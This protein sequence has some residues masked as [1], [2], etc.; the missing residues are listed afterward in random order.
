MSKTQYCES[1]GKECSIQESQVGRKVRCSCGHVFVANSSGGANIIVDT[2]ADVAGLERVKGFSWKNLFAEVFRSHTEEELE[3]HWSAGSVGNI[4]TID[5]VDSSWPQPWVFVRV[6]FL[7]LLAYGLLYFGWAYWTNINLIPGLIA[8]GSFAVPF[9]LVIF[10]FEMNVRKNVSFHLAVKAFFV[11]GTLSLIT[12]LFMSDVTTALGLDWLKASA[13]GIA[14]EPGKILAVIIF[15]RS[16]R[17]GYILNGLLFGAAVGAGFAAFESAGYAMKTLLISVIEQA[18]ASEEVGQVSIKS[19]NFAPMFN[20]ILTRAWLVGLAGHV[21]WT[22]M[23]AGALWRVKGS[24]PFHW[25]MLLDFRFLRIFVIAVACHMI[26]NSTWN[27]TIV[28]PH[29]KRILLGI[30]C[31]GVIFAMIQSGLNQIRREQENYRAVPAS[32]TATAFRPATRREDS[33]EAG[34]GPVIQEQAAYVKTLTTPIVIL[35]Q[36]ISALEKKRDKDHLNIQDK[37]DASTER[38]T[39]RE[40]PT[41]SQRAWKKYYKKDQSE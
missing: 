14:E 16:A 33:A 8:L 30:I 11:G 35:Q 6:F 32:A 24:R 1:C 26:W 12:S 38:E 25:S 10:F 29:D 34:L 7:T 27:P 19:E 28:T 40:T 3:R 13:A 4:P 15:V 36:E 22:G 41:F 20:I 17:Y 21:L 31:W 9:S 39:H 37:I 2:I 18:V 23:S 5:K